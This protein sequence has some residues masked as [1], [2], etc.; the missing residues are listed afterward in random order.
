MTGPAE[1]KT[2]KPYVVSKQRQTWS[3]EEHERFVEAIKLYTRDWK[4][5]EAHVGTKTA[6]QIRS[7]AQKFFQKLERCGEGDSV[8]PPRSKRKA[9]TDAP[10][11]EAN[12]AASS[13]L[14]G[15]ASG[16]S[17]K[18]QAGSQSTGATATTGATANTAG[19]AG[20]AT[21]GGTTGTGRTHSLA[22]AAATTVAPGL[23]E[24][25]TKS[26][27]GG[28]VGDGS[29]LKGSLEG[30][31]GPRRHARQHLSSGTKSSGAS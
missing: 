27:S 20:T 22:S 5:I 8:P 12:G 29:S 10:A 7:H 26:S 1:G 16:A 31:L 3:D 30:S 28:S 19:T 18:R 23:K 9:R 2:R 17:S 25:A 21:T 11:K 14:N 6:V 4:K 15:A 24:E 13:G